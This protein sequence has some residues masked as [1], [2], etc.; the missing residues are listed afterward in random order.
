MTEDQD[1]LDHYIAAASHVFDL[2]VRP[3]WQPP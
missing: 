2:P 3:E 1:P